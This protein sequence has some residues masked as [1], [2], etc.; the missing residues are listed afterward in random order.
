MWIVSR[1]L[2]TADRRHFPVGFARPLRYSPVGDVPIPQ[3]PALPIQIH[4][5]DGADTSQSVSGTHDR[6]LTTGLNSPRSALFLT[7]SHLS[8]PIAKRRRLPGH[9]RGRHCVEIVKPG[10]NVS[11]TRQSL[12]RVRSLDVRC[13][14]IEPG[15][16]DAA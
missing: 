8:R 9:S 7:R 15:A 12:E 2:S 1:S 16:W 5:D 10:A 13:A 4:S 11:R 3:Q 6:A 14:G